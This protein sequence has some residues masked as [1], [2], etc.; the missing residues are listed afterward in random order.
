MKP[1]I[2]ITEETEGQGSAAE[3]SDTVEF[4]SQVFLSRGDRI[5]ARSAASTR[6][7]SRQVI[8]GVEYSLVGM[9]VGGYR[10]VITA[11]ILPTETQE[12]P[13]RFRPMPS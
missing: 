3:Q 6:I 13:T 7:G 12:F 4:E 1:G 2:K 11:H 10:K 5:Q 9:K 8:A